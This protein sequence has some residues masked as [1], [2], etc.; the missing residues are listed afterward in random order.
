MPPPDSANTPLVHQLVIEPPFFVWPHPE[1]RP[2]N[3][4]LPP[5]LGIGCPGKCTRERNS[6]LVFL[7]SRILLR[8]LLPKT[9]LR[10]L[11]LSSR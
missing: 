10:E 1:N 4:K 11:L 6:G 9:S 7:V 3:A 5:P 8:A 2:I